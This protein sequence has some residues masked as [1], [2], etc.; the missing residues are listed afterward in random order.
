MRNKSIIPVCCLILFGISAGAQA[1]TTKIMAYNTGVAWSDSAVFL[2]GGLIP[3]GTDFLAI[4]TN[5]ES[6]SDP[7][8]NLGDNQILY[9]LDIKKKALIKKIDVAGQGYYWLEPS[10]TTNSFVLSYSDSNG[11]RYISL[12]NFDKKR[13][14]WSLVPDT[15]QLVTT[16]YATA[17]SYALL[18]AYFVNT[19]SRNDTLWLDVYKY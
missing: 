4:I 8:S 6:M 15:T 5:R 7:V 18:P 13:R 3:I 11:N 16:G 19:V 9:I 10:A 12:Y 1:Q 14:T 17:G 2:Q